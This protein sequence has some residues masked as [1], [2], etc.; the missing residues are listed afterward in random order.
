MG[1]WYWSTDKR[2]CLQ[3]VDFL[4]FCFIPHYRS[5]YGADTLEG[6]VEWDDVYSLITK[7]NTKNY[8]IYALEEG[9]FVVIEK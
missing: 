9:D 8:P 6:P 4:P 2:D 3:G 5:D 7:R 1:D